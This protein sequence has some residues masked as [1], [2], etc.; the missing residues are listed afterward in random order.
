MMYSLSKLF[1]LAK[2]LLV[3]CLFKNISKHTY[4]V[5]I[6]NFYFRLTVLKSFMCSL[7][8]S[9]QRRTPMLFVYQLAAG[10]IDGVCCWHQICSSKLTKVVSGIQTMRQSL[11]VKVGCKEKSE[12][13][14]LITQR[15]SL[16]VWISLSD[17]SV[18][19]F[20]YSSSHS[21]FSACSPFV[22]PLFALVSK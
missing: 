17:L 18:P 6:S 10:T 4:K 15:L 8:E 16:S 7:W 3:L 22:L 1:W 20:I 11:R 19:L 5:I 2:L 9:R 21:V 13:H 12:I 14:I